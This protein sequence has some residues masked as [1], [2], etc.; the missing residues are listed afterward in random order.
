MS[1]PVTGFLEASVRLASM[2][3]PAGATTAEED[4]NDHVERVRSAIV[5]PM[6]R[7][8]R[9]LRVP[10][11]VA[12]QMLTGVGEGPRPYDRYLL[13]P[14]AQAL[15]AAELADP[16][17]A[18]QADRVMSAWRGVL[19]ELASGAV[20]SSV[21]ATI[22]GDRWKSTVDPGDFPGATQ[23]SIDSSWGTWDA[24]ARSALGS[25][26]PSIEVGDRLALLLG[27]WAGAGRTPQLAADWSKAEAWIDSGSHVIS[28]ES[29]LG[30][31]RV[32]AMS[33]SSPV[34]QQADRHAVD[35]FVSW[36]Y[37]RAGTWP[38][39]TSADP[40]IHSRLREQW[41]EPP[42][43]SEERW[44]PWVK[45]AVSI[46]AIKE[47]KARPT[48]VRAPVATTDG[49]LA[50]LGAMIGLEQVKAEI[51]RIVNLARMEQARAAQGLPTSIINL[52][53]VFSG[54]PG[55]GKT[56]VARLYG[57]ILRSLGLLSSGNFIE[58]TRAD[59]V[60]KYRAEASE[61][62]R[63]ALDAADGGVL[64]I[65]EAYSLTE[66]GSH[67]D[68]A[69]V[70]N[71]LVAAMES[72]RGSFALVGAGDPGSVARFVESNPGLGSRF[73]DTVLF[74]DLSNE[75]LFDALVGILAADGYRIDEAAIPPIKDWISAIPRGE[76]FGNVRDMRKLTGIL[77]E[78]MASR[79]A[80]DPSA[81]PIEVVLKSDVPT[82]GPGEFD[83]RAYELAMADLDS[84]V[85]L[86]PVKAAIRG[87]ADK[88]RLA[89]LVQARGKPV[90]P[91]DIGH[92]V[93]TGNPGTGKTTVAAGIGRILV[94]LGLL[95]NGHVH[96]VGQA[97]L[98]G[99]YLGQTAP[100]VRAAIQQALD[101][102]LFIDEAY[103]LTPS[104]H[105]G[106]YQREAVTTLVDEMER[107][108][109]RLVVIMAG[110]PEQMDEFLRSNEGLKS[111]VAHSID[112]P[113][114]DRTQLR[115]IAVS[116][117]HQRRMRIDDDAA[118]SVA[119]QCAAMA[120]QPGFA[121]ARTVRN[122]V[123]DA[124]TRHASRVVGDA[125]LQNDSRAL[126]TIEK[127]DVREVESATAVPFGFIA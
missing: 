19:G 17:V 23:A 4:A 94:A 21:L 48:V 110:Y 22:E 13:P 86:A 102:V 71:E 116:M 72:R 127:Q 106:A 14:A 33:S 26:P 66:G 61:K 99:E 25:L 119:D 2:G 53:M 55:T 34:Y 97:S 125:Q 121:N 122:M 6:P 96:V 81:D 43:A 37:R 30:A 15:S 24:S 85:G 56:T 105:A 32:W 44:L 74:P 54:N 80:L 58:V 12:G 103:S 41:P 16:Q 51:A 123:D 49:L 118:D 84:L 45:E 100:K 59:L 7:T 27:L 76:G 88:A 108:R 1:D 77:R 109:G 89:Q 115:S 5:L 52:H 95:R 46:N 91:I 40:E 38:T 3:D 104:T 29:D 39:F 69:E 101:G 124:I 8:E 78:S 50:D 68:G 10:P 31:A 62:T 47:P 64:F 114:F 117:A 107:H 82:L 111:R 42:V 92:M 79:F 63:R 75:A 87:L 57:Q 11:E 126:V 60:G 70:I 113:D 18:A 20:L 67:G 112:F 93:F 73:R 83:Q 28:A 35:A 65:D 36:A 120:A 98:I 9:R 90:A